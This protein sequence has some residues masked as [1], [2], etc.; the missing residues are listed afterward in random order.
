MKK[1]LIGI[2]VV[3]V[4]AVVAVTLLIGNL[5]GLIKKGVETA[6]PKILQ[7]DVKLADVDISVSSGSGELKGFMIGNPSGF[8]TEYAF[9][10]DRIKIEL[11]P[12]SVTS[13]TIH[14][15][16]VLIEGPKIIYEGALG[17]SNINQ[18]QA[19]AEA[20][21][22][23][24]GGETASEKGTD[25]SKSGKKV[26]IDYLKISGGEASLSMN[27]LQGQKVTVPLP[28]IEL[29]D[30]GKKKGV[31]FAGAMQQVL[32]AVN[33]ALVPAIQSQ[34]TKLG[35]PGGLQEGADKVQQEAQKGLDTLK[36]MF[37]K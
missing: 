2:G 3:I 20:F 35:L 32:L 31:D 27:M 12:K 4:I 36:G 29:R 10:M 13:D 7:A 17:Q 18:L 25:G 26:M 37:G 5:G 9:D 8:N 24:K 1:L 30:I 19:N 34:F 6:G 16:S 11:D 15:K 22:G 14:I 33:K 23:G 28:Q 21:A